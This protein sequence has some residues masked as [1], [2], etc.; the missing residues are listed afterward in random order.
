ML[1]RT[2]VNWNCHILKILYTTF[3]RPHLEYAS[4][5]WSPYMKKDIKC[6][7]NIQR[8]ATKLVNEI[9]NLSYEDRLKK[10]GLT[11]LEERRVRGDLI[12]YYKCIN[13]FNRVNWSKPNLG[14]NSVGLSGPAG[15]IRGHKHRLNRQFIRNFPQ[16][17]NF[18]V[19]RVVPHW[20]ELPSSVISSKSIESFK[21]NYDKFKSGIIL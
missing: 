3:V 14:A 19:N 8:R 9:K 7:E 1:K 15:N 4:P 10:L 20:N 6:L 12:Q 11:T 2:L 21:I 5:A 16:R 17:E 18:F 13:G